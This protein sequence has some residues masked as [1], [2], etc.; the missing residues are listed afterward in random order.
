MT[1]A[2]RGAA[3]VFLDGR[4]V[5]AGAARVSPF[6]RGFLYGDGL[7][8]T[9]RIYDGR[10][11][12]LDEHLERMR[13]AARRVRLRIP[14]ATRWWES[15]I[16]E[17][18]GRN[19]LSRSEAAVRITVT[20]GLGGDGLVAPRRNKPTIFAI[21][22]SIPRNLASWQTKGVAVIVLPFHPGVGGYLSGL[23]TTDYL[24]AIVGK[25]L[26]HERG[27]FEGLYKA[28]SG[29]I[30]EGTTSNVFI[31][32]R[33]II[34]TPPVCQGILAGITRRHVI[35]VAVRAGMRVVERDVHVS[36]VMKADEAFL[37]ASTIEI[38]PIIRVDGRALRRSGNT[39]ATIQE[40][41]RRSRVRRDAIPDSR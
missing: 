20:R 7:F 11:F 19:R 26:A 13:S 33:G 21:A 24:T 31:V 30:L 41:F 25:A 29:H 32:R 6:D 2:Q 10:A 8:E 35:D 38:V 36:E 23:K 28:S 37:T 1:V 18:L 22:R 15:M 4:F 14:S 3:T 5:A 34:A 9:I 40:L 39:V 27:A 12:A 17:L 16:R